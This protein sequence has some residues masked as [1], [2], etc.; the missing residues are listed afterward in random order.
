MCEMRLAY[1]CHPV[2]GKDMIETDAN[3]HRAKLWLRWATLAH[4]SVAVIAPYI[5]MCEV[6]DDSDQAMRERGI[7]TDLAVIDRCDE[8]WLCGGR[9]SRGMKLELAHAQDRGLFIRDF[10]DLGEV[11]PKELKI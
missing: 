7:A 10:T 1:L 3:L 6:M 4:P 11:P 9:V 5:P 2:S 8:I